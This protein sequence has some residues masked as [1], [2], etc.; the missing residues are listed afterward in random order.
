MNRK[1]ETPHDR[2]AAD[3]FRLQM[4]TLALAG[5]LLMVL[6][7]VTIL[8]T[9][10]GRSVDQISSTLAMIATTLGT[11]VTT[12]LMLL[13][14]Q[15]QTE[16]QTEMLSKIDEQTNG[17]LTQKINDAIAAEIDRRDTEPPTKAVKPPF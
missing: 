5:V 16:Q 2:A 13:K 6:C 1:I 17:I 7:G 9:W 12:V 3:K 8:L 4:A 14:L 11:L 10:Q 15:G